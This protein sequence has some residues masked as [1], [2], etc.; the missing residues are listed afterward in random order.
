[1]AILKEKKLPDTKA[2]RALSPNI[3]LQEVFMDANLRSHAYY[4]DERTLIFNAD[5]RQALRW[6]K[7]AGVEVDCIVTSPP[8]Y[9]QRDYGVDGQLGLEE[10]PTTFI[11]GLVEVFEGC[12]EVLRDTGSLWVNL[13]DTYWS[14]KGQ[15]RSDEKKQS[16]RRFGLRPQDR[17]GDGKWCRPKQLLLIP[18]RFAIAMQDADWL[19]R[20]DNVWIKPNPIPD[21]V[22]DRCSIS[23]EYVFH[24]V[25]ERWYYFNRD[26]VA[27]HNDKGS[28]LPPLDTWIVPPSRQSK[29]HKATFSEEL[30]NIPIRSTTPANGIVLDPF[31]GSGTTLWLARKLGFRTIGIDISAQF[32]E[33]M[34]NQARSMAEAIDFPAPIEI[35]APSVADLAQAVDQV[36]H[37]SSSK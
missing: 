24:F 16:A 33:L 19:V 26:A 20:N 34:A 32:C 4:A 37:L 30:I 5:S 13:G 15:H 1:M 8:F 35:E 3:T 9:G 25:K 7:E 23:H 10:H 22:R 31:G 21:Q 6:L 29:G 27:R 14:G 17:K 28:S 11:N 2:N 18:H 12:K 36:A